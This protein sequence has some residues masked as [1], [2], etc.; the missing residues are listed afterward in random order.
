[1][2]ENSFAVPHWIVNAL[3]VLCGMGLGGLIVRVV[4]LWQN[5]KRPAVEVQKLEAETTEITIRSHSTAGD[6]LTRMMDRLELAQTRNDD[7]REENADLETENDR[8]RGDVEAYERQ[9]T[10]VRR[11]MEDNGLDFNDLI[12]KADEVKKA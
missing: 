11:F 2:Q 5:R 3:Q 4:T 7:L 9:M 12:V 6:S 1:M 10:R 8:L